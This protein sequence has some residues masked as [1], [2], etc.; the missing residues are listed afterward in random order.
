MAFQKLKNYEHC[1]NRYR[2]IQKYSRFTAQYISK[3]FNL[4]NFIN[5][6]MQ[7]TA[8]LAGSAAAA[9]AAAPYA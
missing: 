5:L 8:N 2:M 7:K 6:K 1:S 4:T 9:A 3:L